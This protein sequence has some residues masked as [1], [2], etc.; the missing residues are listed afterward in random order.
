MGLENKEAQLFLGS[1][2]VFVTDIAITAQVNVISTKK[3]ITNNNYL[4][5][6]LQA[7]SHTPSNVRSQVSFYSCQNMARV[8]ESQIQFSPRRQK[9]SKR[10]IRHVQPFVYQLRYATV[11][12]LQLPCSNV[13]NHNNQQPRRPMTRVGFETRPFA[14]KGGGER[15]RERERKEKSMLT[16]K[17]RSGGLKQ[18]YA[19]GYITEIWQR[20][21]LNIALI[22]DWTTRGSNPGGRGGAKFSSPVQ[23]GPGGPSSLL[24][25]SLSRGQSGRG[26]ALTTHRHLA[27]RLKREQSYTSTPPLG[28]RDLFQ[29][30]LYLTFLLIKDYE[31]IQVPVGWQPR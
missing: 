25:G 14:A 9:I 1:F 19:N 21:E 6:A 2:C 10:Y 5:S 15:E 8:F 18:H 13:R 28:L 17:P 24:H 16:T 22:N 7:I 23:T 31:G 27:Q 3:T 29:G 11:M 12:F 20:H 4:L 26:L 30:E